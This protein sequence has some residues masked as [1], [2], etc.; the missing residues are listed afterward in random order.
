[1]AV[2]ARA[3]RTMVDLNDPIQQGAAP[4]NPLV[5]MLWLDISQSPPVM[6]RWSGAAW[7]QVG[8][9]TIGGVNLIENSET[10]T[11]VGD[12]SNTYWMG[13]DELAASTTY[14][15][16]V[17]EVIKN[18]GSAAGVT[19]AL[20]NLTTSA[21]AQTGTLDFTYGKQVR[22]FTVPATAANWA[23]LLYAGLSGATNGVS[24]TFNKAQL[25][26]GNVATAWALAPQDLA[27]QIGEVGGGLDALDE[28]LAERI[29]GIIDDMGLTGQFP[30]IADFLALVGRVNSVRSD[31]DLN[32]DN[33]SLA[34][35][36]LIATE[37]SVTQIFTNFTFGSDTD[38]TPYIDM[39]V[40]DSPMKMRLTNARLSFKQG[41]NEVAYLSDNKLYVTQLEVV[42]RVSIGTPTNGYL[43]I[44]T[45]P[46]GVGFKWRS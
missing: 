46:T 30:S 2:I 43:D 18:A 6:Y 4:G 10:Q 33:L 39:G 13:A 35:S 36:R 17:R 44:V 22:S 9:Q 45:T 21:V 8:K 24:V 42:E 40:S 26:E 38:G 31:L 14:T 12:D 1:M 11:V 32:D 3:I 5:G 7:E 25:E 23:F 41:T 37:G 20:M 28:A 34:F 15:F 19:W 16:S 29:Q 27:A